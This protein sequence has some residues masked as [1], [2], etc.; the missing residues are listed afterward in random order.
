MSIHNYY[1]LLED[2]CTDNIENIP[3]H[4]RGILNNTNTTKLY[5]IHNNHAINIRPKHTRWD[6]SPITKSTI[7]RRI[8]W[9]VSSTA[10]VNI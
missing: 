3:V 5:T 6:T 1:G 2:T 8:R 4:T 9:V 10:K 7:T